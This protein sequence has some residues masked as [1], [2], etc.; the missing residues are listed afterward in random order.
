MKDD[1]GSNIP[2]VNLMELDSYKCPECGCEEFKRVIYLKKIPGIMIGSGGGNEIY[3]VPMYK[4]TKCGKILNLDEVYKEIN[5][6]KKK[7]NLI[8]S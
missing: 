7:P 5:S 6:D 1:L 8:L 3:P 4:C 2:S